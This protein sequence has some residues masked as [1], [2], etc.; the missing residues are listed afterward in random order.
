MIDT[1]C[2]NC[3]EALAGPFCY[4]C[5]ERRL[6]PEHVTIRHFAGESLEAITDLDGRLWRSV[7]LLFTH[8]G[9][10]TADYMAGRRQRYVRPLQLFLLFNVVYFVF[11]SAAGQTTYTTPLDTHLNLVHG[12]L[13]RRMVSA[14]IEGDEVPFVQYEATFN[15]V[16]ANQ[17]ATLII[18]MIPV[19]ALL[20]FALH[21][22]LRRP[23]V[24]HLVLSAHFYAYLLLVEALL[25][26]ILFPIRLL[27]RT[28][29]LNL[30]FL[31]G[32]GFWLPVMVAAI[33]YFLFFALRRVYG[34]SAPIRALKTLLL[35][36]GLF[37]V[38]HFY[39]FLLFFTTF[40]SI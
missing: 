32:D 33:C 40:Y 2:A 37:W 10:L 9:Q 24:E 11:Q 31:N 4:R 22:R 28:V 14:E 29:G 12:A 1:E 17:A 13:A 8:P 15:A 34:Q 19:F 25:L 18:A 26:G 30:A 38:I 23:Y 5:G 20:L 16:T 21:G 3:G 35:V 39:R 36:F 6:E 7:R 27:A